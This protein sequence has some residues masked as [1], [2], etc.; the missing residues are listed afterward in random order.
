MI[1]GYTEK[2]LYP[3]SKF[4]LRQVH[5]RYGCFW[6]NHFSTI[7]I[8]GM[9]ECCLNFLG[10]SIATEEGSA[11]SRKVM[12]FMRE[13]MAEFQEETGNIYNLE[14]TPAERCV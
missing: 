10:V 11:F 3:Y 7:G 2:G 6:K 5:D 14:A 1:E 8:N 4:Y 13:V 9:N 12:T